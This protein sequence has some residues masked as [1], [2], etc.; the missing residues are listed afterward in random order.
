MNN[1]SRVSELNFPLSPNV[2]PAR[3]T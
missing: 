1:Q 2:K 3:T